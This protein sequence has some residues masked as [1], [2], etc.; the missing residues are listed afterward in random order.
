[1]TSWFVAD[2]PSRIE[3]DVAE[4]CSR[5]A[6][7]SKSAW[8]KDASWFARDH[9]TNRAIQYAGVLYYV[10]LGL[11][12]PLGAPIPNGARV[13]HSGYLAKDYHGR[14]RNAARVRRQVRRLPA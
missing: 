12:G 3:R 9:I 1:M 7:T 4:T 8:R 11:F 6:T 14:A 2:A 10:F 5:A 13:Y